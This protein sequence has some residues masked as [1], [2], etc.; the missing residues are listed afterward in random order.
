M[1]RRMAWTARL[2]EL[3]AERGQGVDGGGHLPAEPD[4]APHRRRVEGQLLALGGGLLGRGERGH[5]LLGDRAQLLLRPEPG[6]GRARPPPARRWRRAP[7][8]ARP[9]SGTEAGGGI[10]AAASTASGTAASATV[11]SSKMPSNDRSSSSAEMEGVGAGLGVGAGGRAAGGLGAAITGRGRG[12]A[13]GGGGVGAGRTATRAGWG[14]RTGPARRAGAGACGASRAAITRVAAS[15]TGRPSPRQ[16]T[17]ALAVAEI[18]ATS[19]ANSG[20]SAATT[21]SSGPAAP[22]S[23]PQSESHSRPPCS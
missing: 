1:P 15:R 20:G 5:D 17:T 11:S 6:E 12:V 14:V 13:A 22:R 7:S 8:R 10:G 4:G 21:I 23:S 18:S 19:P 3:G 2:V 9:R 16:A